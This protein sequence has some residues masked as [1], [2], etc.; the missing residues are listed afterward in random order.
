MNINTFVKNYKVNNIAAAD[1]DK[2]SNEIWSNYLLHV[3]GKLPHLIEITKKHVASRY[4]VPNIVPFVARFSC[5][6]SEVFMITESN[7]I[8][9]ACLG[10]LILDHFTQ[11]LDDIDDIPSHNDVLSIHG[12]HELMLEGIATMMKTCN[13][14]RWLFETLNSYV[15]EAMRN[16]RR[17]L[18]LKNA[19]DIFG[20]EDYK[21]MAFR[22]GIM[23]APAAFYADYAEK[24]DILSAVED[25]ILRISLAI[26]LLDDIVDWQEDFYQKKRTSILN[27]FIG[28]IRSE[29]MKIEEVFS[30]IFEKGLF[31][32][33]INRAITEIDKAQ[34]VLADLNGDITLK[35]LDDIKISAKKALKMIQQRK[36]TGNTVDDINDFNKDILRVS[37]TNMMH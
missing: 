20:N 37:G 7:V 30:G 8:G 3:A 35:I 1:I 28:R 16:E 14:P 9:S 15:L 18:D 26:Q 11:T 32:K 2:I 23:R 17:L 31:E 13:D 33:N 4:N 19:S 10:T 25:C 24:I 5:A 36:K 27:H 21:A 34:S 6:L 29:K 22:G 12:S